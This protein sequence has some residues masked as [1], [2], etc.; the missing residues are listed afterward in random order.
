MG[1]ELFSR[2]GCL[3]HGAQ[4]PTPELQS[5]VLPR[6]PRYEPEP[7]PEPLCHQ[8]RCLPTAPT[9]RP[10]QA[11]VLTFELLLESKLSALIKKQNAKQMR[12]AR[13][14]SAVLG[15]TLWY[16]AGFGAV[17]GGTRRYS[18]VLGGTLRDSERYPMAFRIK[19]CWTY[20]FFFLTT[21]PSTAA[22]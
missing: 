11:I 9:Q 13:R 7:P 22:T 2:I 1:F 18:A 4:P 15:G 16:S 10:A 17:L 21:Q 12:G 5:P 3:R 20:F 19:L 14:Y 8:P 6:A